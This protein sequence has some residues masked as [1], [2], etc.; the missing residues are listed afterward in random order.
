MTGMGADPPTRAGPGGG[1]DRT[2]TRSGSTSSATGGF[3]FAPAVRLTPG[4]LLGTRYEILDV[5]GEGG[6]GTVYKARDR[7][8]G[9]LVAL[10]I[11]RPEMAAR[12]EIL[13]RFKREILLASQVTHRNVLRI[14]DL[15]EA[16]EIRFISMSYVEGS[17]LKALLASAGPL[18]LEKGLP[19]ARQIGEAL[20]AAHDAGIVHR[21]LKPQNIL[22]DR[23]GNAYISDFGISR[24]L[25]EGGT[26]TET[27]AILGTVDYMSPEQARGE[28]PDHRGDIYS[29]GVILYEMFTGGLPFRASN[30]LS[31]MMKRL[32]EDAPT[33][34]KARPGLPAWLS[35]I[36]ARA[37][38]REPRH[39]YASAKD[40][41]RDL[42]RQRA[43]RS[44]R[45]F[46][47]AR[48]LVPASAVL[49]AAAAAAVVPR[50]PWPPWG[51][52]AAP[53]VLTSLVVLPFQNATGDA[54][55]DWVAA[56]LPSL[57][58][59][60]LLQAKSLRLVG[61]D[62]VLEILGTLKV[63]GDDLA[64]TTVQRIGGLLG[65]DH[66]LTGRVVK[67]ADRLR[68]DARLR[69]PPASE[70]ALVVDGQGDQ[71]IF[72]MV[73]DLTNRVR[74]SLGVSRGWSEDRRG[75]T[76]LSTKSVEAL[77]LYSEAL[78]L[79]R[80]GQDLEA[81]RRLEA[82]I[83]K[84]P[85]FAVARAL[86]A[87]TY[88]RLG[89]TD[90]ALAQ[91]NQAV[92]GIGSSSPYEATRIRAVQARL[93]NNP[94]EA[95][96]AYTR[97]TEIT[98]NNPE[99][100]LDLASFQEEQGE[101]SQTLVTLRRVVLLDGKNPNAHYA[102][103]RVQFKLGN[104]A[105]ALQ[106]FT[107]A[108]AGHTESGNEEGRASVLNGLGNAHHALGRNEDALKNYRDS[109]EIRRKLQDL[110][111]VASV[112]N[113]IAIA[114]S[115]LGQYEEA[116]QTGLEAVATA[117]QI[118]DRSDL[119]D[120]YGEMGDIYLDAGRP[121]DALRSYQEGLSIVREANDPASLARSLS[122]V[123]YINTVL[124]HYV[125]AFFFLKDA[126]A[127]NREI[128]DRGE[129]VRSLI[130]IGIVEQV[131][132]RY[133]EALK[134]EME[135]LAIAREIDNKTGQVVLSVNL[136]NIHE[137][138]GEYGPA[139]SFLS[140]A[141]TL[142]RG[143]KDNKLVAT[144]LMYAG[145]VRRSVGDF[146][147]AGK[148]LDEALQLMRQIKNVPLEAETL[149]KQADLLLARGQ[150]DRAAATARQAE[151]LARRSGG[152]PRVRLLAR[153]VTGQATGAVRDLEAVLKEAGTVG[154]Q[155]IAASTHLALARLHLS[156][157]RTREAT[158]E[159]GRAAEMA[160]RMNLRDVLFQ[161]QC[162]AGRSLAKTGPA[163]EAAAKFQAAGE[164]L[165]EMLRGLSGETR[166]RFLGRPDIVA[167]RS[168]AEGTLRASGRGQEADRIRDLAKP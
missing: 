18:P 37:M 31:I 69:T 133:E 16:G 62:R 21:D 144:C 158:G 41:L 150:N 8:L 85:K 145:G 112:L 110:R 87:E 15:G 79:S 164:A 73:D 39:R 56:G 157:G 166:T 89:H 140:D 116:I 139:L 4:T 131:Q 30:A 20:Q 152:D 119:V 66:V 113:N 76:D 5:L 104:P 102:L 48:Y 90:K 14:H 35:A 149:V 168:D 23:E 40:L 61:E 167:F 33:I 25:A 154:L 63:T 155:S 137:E 95:E 98:P 52:A 86:L 93:N 27:G 28:T 151:G 53:P 71:A 143:L 7:E 83:D 84:D 109:L 43:A 49:L 128:G 127:K 3:G 105:D 67:I 96:K 107:T 54:H 115:E 64:P 123:G 32:H 165:G 38:Q 81:S 135:G 114:Q 44:W 129:I 124:G 159:A 163:A 50:L 94:V 125:E 120:I 80:S 60:E 103:G 108:L 36:V 46:V 2:I 100:F 162:A 117:K 45:R 121:E 146:E 1:S 130:D 142:A 57:L 118:D 82:S 91:A 74:D 12:P 58:R 88:D 99:A 70:A 29:F 6:M 68:I 148:D 134:Y 47:R 65:A 42:D 160:T 136:S 141:E 34:Q 55:Y 75:A 111:G 147:P 13:E 19:I 92:A 126:L 26:M 161:A 9:R 132:G 77:A 22:I 101:L 78:G 138:Q 106:E 122:N 59:S 24:S 10:K 97:L 153:L 17:D 51:A 156:S 11:I 72:T